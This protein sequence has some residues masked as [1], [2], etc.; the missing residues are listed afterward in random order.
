LFKLEVG[1]NK[2]EVIE[3]NVYITAGTVDYLKK[4]ENKYPSETMVTLANA[5]AALLL[6]E[7]DGGTVFKEPRK[8]DVLDSAGEFKESGFVVMNNVPVTDEGRPLFENEYHDRAKILSNDPGFIAARVLRPLSSNP[9]IILTIWESEVNFQTSKNLHQFSS[10]LEQKEL[11]ID[12]L[13]KI[14]TSNP[15]INQ[16]TIIN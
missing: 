6:H 9:Y 5:T 8:Y 10:L 3:M 13:P 16:Y 15:Y 14:F 11:G 12:Q 4:I 7:T 1:Y 2:E